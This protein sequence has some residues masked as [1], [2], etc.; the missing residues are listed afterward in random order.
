MSPSQNC[1]HPPALPSFSLSLSALSVSGACL[2]PVAVLRKTSSLTHIDSLAPSPSPRHIP[3]RITSFADPHRLTPIESHLCEKQGRGWGRLFVA[4]LF[5]P[6]RTRTLATPIP[7]CAYQR[8]SGYPGG[9]GHAHPNT[10][11]LTHTTNVPIRGLG[12]HESRDTGHRTPDTDHVTASQPP[13]TFQPSTS[14]STIP[15]LHSGAYF[16]RGFDER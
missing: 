14:S 1:L 9:G 2:D 11:S 16:L 10:P 12:T 7:S 15:A 8:F 5:H 4:L 6:S 13:S 3:F